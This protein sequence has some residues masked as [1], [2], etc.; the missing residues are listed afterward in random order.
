MQ[1]PDE[2]VIAPTPE[3]LAGLDYWRTL[4]IKQQPQWSD[5]SQ[6]AKVASELSSLPPLVF[7]GPHA[8]NE[9]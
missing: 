5:P 6:V 1:M 7:A 8:G 4:E 2:S 9:G 3:L